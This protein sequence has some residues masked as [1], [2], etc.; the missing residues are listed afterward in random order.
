[1]LLPLQLHLFAPF[2]PLSLNSLDLAGVRLLSPRDSQILPKPVA[3]ADDA[4][5]DD[6]T[7]LRWELNAD[8]GRCYVSFH[9]DQ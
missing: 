1:M 4:S 8:L 7:E 9:V 5:A 3:G 2:P 6:A